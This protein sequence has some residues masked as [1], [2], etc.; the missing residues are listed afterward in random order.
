MRNFVKII[1][2]VLISMISLHTYGQSIGVKAGLNLS[3]MLVED[4]DGTQSDDFDMKPGFHI[5]AMAEIPFSPFMAFEGGIMFNTKGYKSEEEEQGVTV[6]E[7]LALN[8][9]DIPVTIK[10]A[11][12]AAGFKVYGA[13]GPYVGMGI[14]GKYKSEMEG[15]GMSVSDEEDI[16]FGTD[17]EEDNL[18]PLDFGLTFGAGVEIRSLIVG[19]SYDYGL[20]NIAI[21]TDGGTKVQNRVLRISLGYKLGL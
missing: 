12:G 20:A 1:S 21:N 11:G 9:I 18:K 4:D 10:V 14:S 16:N 19:V 3:N 8:Y 17:E 6:T 15:G 13:A 5:G 2:I 7:N